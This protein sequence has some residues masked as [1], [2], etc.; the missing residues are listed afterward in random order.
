[1]RGGVGSLADLEILRSCSFP[2]CSFD[3]LVLIV[4]VTLT[5]QGPE[6]TGFRRANLQG[7]QTLGQGAPQAD[8]GA[9]TTGK[10]AL[11]FEA[12]Q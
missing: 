8:L 12:A 10:R 2:L 5:G 6:V 7:A 9:P 11:D 3:Q 4:E 1:M